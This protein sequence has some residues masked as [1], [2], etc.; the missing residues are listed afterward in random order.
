M[1]LTPPITHPVPYRLLMFDADGTL[2]GCTVPGRPP[3]TAEESVL[4][5]N[6][7]VM[8][9]RYQWK[10]QHFFG[11]A[12]NQG[13]VALGSMPEARCKEMLLQLMH[14]AS[15]Y[16]WPEEVIRFCPHAPQ[17][18]CRCRK[19]APAMLNDIMHYWHK[20]RAIQGPADCLY[21]GDQE[22]DGATAAA[23]GIDVCWAKDFFGW[24]ATP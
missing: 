13:G 19:P 21:V 24:E 10:K 9:S 3:N 4:L 23:A 14:D 11:I 17:A 2:R 1:I 8:L 15:W 20:Q 16:L 7:D 6:V 22:S 18:G 12:S 5:P